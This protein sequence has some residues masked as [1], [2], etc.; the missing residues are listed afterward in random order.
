MAGRGRGVDTLV[1]YD[2]F[3]K[4]HFGSVPVDQHENLFLTG[5]TNPITVTFQKNTLLGD[6]YMSSYAFA[7]IPATSGVPESLI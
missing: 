4:Q 3:Y 5:L 1:K 6:L 7:T 2:E